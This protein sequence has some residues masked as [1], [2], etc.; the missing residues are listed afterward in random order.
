MTPATETPDTDTICAI[1]T[2]PGTG[3]IAVI[4]ISG[5]NAIEIADKIWQ[6]TPLATSRTHTSH[7]GTV[8]DTHGATLDD[9]LATVMRAPHSYTGQDTVEIS[10]HGSTYIQH[11]LIDSLIA[12]GARLALP[13]EYTRRAF[14]AGKIDLA[15]AEAVADIISSQS[16][17]EHTIAINQMRGGYSIRLRQLRQSLIELA[18]LLELELD[19]SEEDVQ[20]ADRATLQAQATQLYNEIK[21]LEQSFAQGNTIKQGIPIAIIGE[22]NVGKSSLLNILLGEDRAI[23]SDIHGTTR[24]IIEDTCHIGDY[25]IRFI[26]T[27]GIRHTSDT[28][29]QM[30]IDRSRQAIN[31][32]SVIT[33]MID[34]TSPTVNQEIASEINSRL[35]SDTSTKLILCIN[36]TDLAPDPTD[37]IIPQLSQLSLHPHAIIP[38]SAV[39]GKGI[40]Q[41]RDT[42]AR[43]AA[44]TLNIQADIIVTNARHRQA[45]SSALPPLRS[46]IDAL[47]IPGH[48]TTP[49]IT[50]YPISGD[51][52]AQDLREALYHIGT[53]TGDIT[54]DDLL[55]T[56][57]SRF[58]IGK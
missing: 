46:V 4:R 47:T 3:G 51:L 12:A 18:S 50:P 42:I 25:T 33:L 43:T 19:F 38:I 5:G 11:A 48:K 8:T 21:Q 17:A 55:S 23:V 49:L 26:D 31:R 44:D 57:F 35:N 9:A 27:A 16:R 39:T 52:I 10:V 15:Q 32:A 37:T 6:G 22:T 20:F 7:Y 53:I 14:A 56:I 30:G 28:I 13:G 24:D 41:L 29:E 40:P 34:A 58:C 54:T 36:K 1:S 2:P 45:L